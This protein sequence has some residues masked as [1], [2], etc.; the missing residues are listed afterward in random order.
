MLKKISILFFS[1]VLVLSTVSFVSARG[2]GDRIRDLRPSRE[3]RALRPP[4]EQ[5]EIIDLICERLLR[6]PFSLPFCEV[7]PEDPEPIC[8]N[9]IV[10]EG[11]ECDTTAPEGFICTDQCLLEEEE[12]EPE[13]NI[14]DHVI[15]NELYP[16]VDEAHG[17]EFDNEWVELYN[18]TDS[19]VDLTG[20]MLGSDTLPTST[21]DALGFA[22]VIPGDV[23]T[24]TLDFWTP[25]TSTEIIL[26]DSR[27]DNGLANGGDSLILKNAS[28]VEVDAMSYGSNTGEL[29]P[30]APKPGAN[31]GESVS[32]VPNGNDNDLGSDW[33]ILETPTP[34]S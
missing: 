27:I 23:P 4:R 20:W 28:A 11:E 18:P 5:R 31:A 30:A 14:A 9:G 1:L 2:F 19:P 7:A 33:M 21:I 6:L 26:V 32:R 15:I 12:G 13:V 17:E 34:G 10:E 25:P 8:G 29:D 16:D 22:F 24:S 3:P